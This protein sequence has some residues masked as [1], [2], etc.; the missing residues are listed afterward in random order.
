MNNH[1]EDVYSAQH[2]VSSGSPWVNE[3]GNPERSGFNVAET[4]KP[5]LSAAWTQPLEVTPHFETL[6][7]GVTGGDGR[8]YL[9]LN[10]TLYALAGHDGKIVWSKEH[11]P[12]SALGVPAWNAGRLYLSVRDRFEAPHPIPGQHTHQCLDANT[13]NLIW[14]EPNLHGTSIDTLSLANAAVYGGQAHFFHTTGGGIIGILH[15]LDRTNGSIRWINGGPIV[16]A[17]IANGWLLASTPND[18]LTFQLQAHELTRG[19]SLGSPGSLFASGL[20]A[21]STT[22]TV[23]VRGPLENTLS[24]VDLRTQTVRW[25][26]TISLSMAS[27][28]ANDGQQVYAL[29]RSNDL[30]A[31]N[32]ETGAV[33]WE[34][35]L[36]GVDLE[37]APVVA[38]GY[39]YVASETSLHVVEAAAGG[40]VWS[41]RAHGGRPIVANG[42]VYLTSRGAD[43][44]VSLRAYRLTP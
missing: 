29:T 11:G 5:P 21:D 31:I 37:F 39:V 40:E 10:T 32:A 9:P 14:K 12:D 18:T 2:S 1:Y 22:R 28:L 8:V 27:M 25:T 19:E 4:G 3:G 26:R 17:A 20:S 41:D 36:G 34:A 24:A 16:P 38:N 23:F 6:R 7:G 44:T 43:S 33:A 42:Y 15:A 30:V 35:D 13:G